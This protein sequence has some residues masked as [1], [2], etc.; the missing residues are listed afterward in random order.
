LASEFNVPIFAND[1]NLTI[2]SDNHLSFTNESKLRIQ[3]IDNWVKLNKFCSHKK[4]KCNFY[5]KIVGHEISQKECVRCVCVARWILNLEAA[6]CSR[7][8]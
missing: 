5:I 6:Y 4:E 1:T 8:P 7:F 2:V 3:K